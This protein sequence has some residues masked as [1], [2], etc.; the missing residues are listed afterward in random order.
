M[1]LL[2]VRSVPR[3]H[4]YAGCVSFFLCRIKAANVIMYVH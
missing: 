1:R 3:G 2:E 4:R